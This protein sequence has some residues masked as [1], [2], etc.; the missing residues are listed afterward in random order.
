MV[1]VCFDP[2]NNS[3][4]VS[5]L[6]NPPLFCVRVQL[7]SCFQSPNMCMVGSFVLLSILFGCNGWW[8]TGALTNM[9]RTAV[10]EICCQDDPSSKFV[11]ESLDGVTVRVHPSETTEFLNE[12]CHGH[13]LCVDNS[14][15]NCR[16]NRAGQTPLQGL[17]I[18]R[19]AV[20]K[21]QR[22]NDLQVV[23]DKDGQTY[24]QG[25]R[26]QTEKVT[27]QQFLLC[28]IGL[29]FGCIL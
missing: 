14:R 6:K 4:I 26:L 15:E 7:C 2:V 22:Q 25:V 5:K 10:L 3:A 21:I 23:Q 28:G 1:L 20:A 13:L 24:A 9:H 19:A 16:F 8:Q 17:T 27:Q 29:H 18:N 12:L 11:S